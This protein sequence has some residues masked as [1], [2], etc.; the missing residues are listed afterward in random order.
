MSDLRENI[1]RYMDIKQIRYY[2]DLLVMIGKEL[3]VKDPYSF[4]E[5]EKSNFSKMLREERPLKH[6]FIIPLEKIFGVSMA[7]LMDDG[8]YKLPVNKEDIPYVKGFRYYAYKDDMALY[9]DE[10]ERTMV[11]NEG[12]PTICNT[13]EFGKHFLDYV[14]EYKSL[15]ALRFLIKKHN[16]KPNLSSP[17][18]FTIEGSHSVSSTMGSELIKM[19]VQ[20][21]DA[22]IFNTIL[23]PFPYFYRCGGRISDFRLDPQVLEFILESKK[24]FASLFKTKT[25]LVTEVNRGIL[26]HDGETMDV[27]NPMLIECLN[28][29]LD[30]LKQFREQAKTIIDFGIKYNTQ[31]LDSTGV[32]LEELFR[33][34]EGRVYYGSYRMITAIVCAK[35]ETDDIEMIKLLEKLP[36]VKK[37]R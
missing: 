20:E 5:K 23:D 31:A 21:D 11:T 18:F 12:F 34:E 3:K 13:D 28:Y 36:T 33:D 10:F 22:E 7:R 29:A 16:L 17:F 4:A 9:E 8:A 14:V 2:S 27:L 1:H 30:N 19:V 32:K 6:E 24:V 37:W 25:M 26:D 35:Q 15:N